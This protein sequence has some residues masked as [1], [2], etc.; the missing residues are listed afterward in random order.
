MNEYGIT[1]YDANDV[2]PAGFAGT[3]WE[4]IFN[5]L[6][7]VLKNN[8]SEEPGAFLYAAAALHYIAKGEYDKITDPAI[9]DGLAAALNVPFWVENSPQTERAA[10]ILHLWLTWS[11]TKSNLRKLALASGMRAFTSHEQYT[12]TE[13][14]YYDRSFLFDLGDGVL[15]SFFAVGSDDTEKYASV[16]VALYR[17]IGRLNYSYPSLLVGSGGVLDYTHPDAMPLGSMFY[18]RADKAEIL[19]LQGY[20]FDLFDTNGSFVYKPDEYAF[21][22]LSVIRD[23]YGKNTAISGQ[24]SLLFLESGQVRL[25]WGQ[26]PASAYALFAQVDINIPD[27]TR[28]WLNVSRSDV[29]I[30]PNA[31]PGIVLLD[32]NGDPISGDYEIFAA[33]GSNCVRIPSESLY[34]VG[35]GP[36]YLRS[37]AYITG[38]NQVWLDGS[39]PPVPEDDPAKPLTF[40]ATADG[41]SVSITI[42]GSTPYAYQYSTDDGATWLSYTFGSTINL[43]S[44]EK[45]S[46]R[47]NADRSTDQSS[48]KYIVF[49][50]SGAIEAYHNVMSL[51]YYSDYENKVSLP[52]AYAL[53][54]L[55]NNCTSLTRA[56]L[57][58]ATTL[59]T[60][61][62]HKMFYGTSIVKAPVLPATTL[63]GHCYR[64]MF[65][66]CTSLTKAPDLP[67]TTLETYCYHSMFYDCSSLEEA[68][69][70]PAS[71][72]GTYCCHSMFR[73]CISLTKAPELYA[74]ALTNYCYTY[75]FYGC[76]N[77]TLIKCH[78]TSFGTSSVV[79]WVA[80]VYSTGDFYA[81]PNTTW[82]NTT[83]GIPS[84]WTRRDLA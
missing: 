59:S 38:I 52:I 42:Y 71:T 70:I 57:L 63:A 69:N 22:I 43:N 21:Y 11:P 8:F 82:P 41:S 30:A 44:G 3:P 60:N 5:A 49:I 4:I 80:N 10:A 9:L 25:Y 28:A 29:N 26:S 31:I 75:M 16:C 64:E 53:Y 51:L 32:S 33:Y 23:N 17:F 45:V 72:L 77:L 15:D 68:P 48:S 2:L 54:K 73:G 35:E 34:L 39:A 83:S 66:G 67:A 7:D 20:N 78:A 81:N 56:P 6:R 37:S 18:F 58:P 61:C 76:S 19:L 24:T 55:F 36:V 27:K 74:E 46:F 84:G 1:L 12:L 62:Y 14:G 65:Y 50:M 79:N 47:V 40:K 13:W